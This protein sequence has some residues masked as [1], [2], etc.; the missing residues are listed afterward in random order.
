MFAVVYF[1]DGKFRIRTFN[2]KKSRSSRAIEQEEFDVN[3][4]L[5][6]NDHTMPN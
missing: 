5:N 2:G 1:D 4:A 3:A 6:L